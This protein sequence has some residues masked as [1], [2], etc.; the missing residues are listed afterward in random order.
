MHRKFN[1]NIKL[2]SFLKSFLGGT[3]AS[4]SLENRQ[5]ISL[6]YI[7]VIGKGFSLKQF[8]PK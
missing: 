7:Y 6:E 8:F 5:L 4:F 1:Y 2:Y 3:R